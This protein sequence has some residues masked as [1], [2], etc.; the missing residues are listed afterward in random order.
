MFVK[1]SL[2]NLIFITV[3][4]IYL[5]ALHTI[6]FNRFIGNLQSHKSLKLNVLSQNDICDHKV[7]FYNYFY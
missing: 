4:S 3:V 6:I 7:L 5:L 2:L 1:F